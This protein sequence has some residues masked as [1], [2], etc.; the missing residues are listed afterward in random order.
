MKNLAFV[1]L[2][3]LCFIASLF[4]CTEETTKRERIEEKIIDADIIRIMKTLDSYNSDLSMTEKYLYA[5]NI[6]L[7]ERKYRNIGITELI[8]I[9]KVETNMKHRKKGK[10]I[11][12]GK[13]DFGISQLDANTARGIASRHGLRWRDEYIHDPALNVYVAGLYLSDLKQEH[14]YNKFVF[15]SYNRGPI[16]KKKIKNFPYWKKIEKAIQEIDEKLRRSEL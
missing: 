5:K 7:L 3:I 4:L 1:F 15:E 12:T 2:I 10:M 8:A 14:K 13:N 6:L 11:V 16:N 9:N